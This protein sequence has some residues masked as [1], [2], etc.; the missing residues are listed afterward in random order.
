MGS[1][2]A[3]PLFNEAN[4]HWD[5]APPVKDHR[6]ELHCSASTYTD[7]KGYEWGADLR[8][9]EAIIKVHF[10][11][12]VLSDLWAAS[13]LVIQSPGTHAHFTPGCVRGVSDLMFDDL[14]PARFLCRETGPNAGNV[15]VARLVV[16]VVWVWFRVPLSLSG[17]RGSG[18]SPVGSSASPRVSSPVRR[19]CVSSSPAWGAS[20]SSSRSSP[21]SSCGVSSPRVSPSMRGRLLV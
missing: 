14:F 8:P 16:G 20:P 1:D 12:L 5:S 17:T 9:K 2:V 7:E 18:G 4:A 11:Y 13:V 3:E 15:C 21:A 6:G 19:L 10:D